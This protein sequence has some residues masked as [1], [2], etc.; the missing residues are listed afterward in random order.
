M[1]AGFFGPDASTRRTTERLGE[2]YPGF[3]RS[4]SIDYG[5]KQV[6][7]NIHSADLVSA[8]LAFHAALRSATVY[9]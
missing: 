4:L 7:D 1:R 9:K 3:F 2:C 8:F 5:G 6:R